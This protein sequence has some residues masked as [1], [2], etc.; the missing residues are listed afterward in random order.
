MSREVPEG[1]RKVTFG[2]VSSINSKSLPVSTA[3]DYSFR[4]IDVS[5]VDGPST[6]LEPRRVTYAEAPS[7]ALRLVQKGDI[8]VSTVRPYLRSFCRVDSD[9]TDL[10][11]STGFA[12]ISP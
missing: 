10:V 12:V 7:R 6:L 9:E 4:Y 3:Q 8:L 11:A 5:T 1:W 2:E